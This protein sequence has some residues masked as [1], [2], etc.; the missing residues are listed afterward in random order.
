MNAPSWV[1]AAV[2]PGRQASRRPPAVGPRRQETQVLEPV[3]LGFGKAHARRCGQ[4]RAWRARRKTCLPKRCEDSIGLAA[5]G[6]DRLGLE[7]HP[8]AEDAE[9][10][11][12]RLASLRYGLLKLWLPRLVATGHMDCR[13]AGLGEQ[14]NKNLRSLALAQAK[15]SA[16]PSLSQATRGCRGA[17]RAPRRPCAA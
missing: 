3:A 9:L 5:A 16:P 12:A 2:S 4:R 10:G 1:T 15:A 8:A 6:E 17:T 14:R 7:Q 13:R 11:T